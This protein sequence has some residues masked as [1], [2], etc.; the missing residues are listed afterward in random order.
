MHIYQSYFMIKTRA[1]AISNYAAQTQII[2][3]ENKHNFYK[4]Q[5][6]F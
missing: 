1:R 5:F 4:F 3:N 2:N 6:N